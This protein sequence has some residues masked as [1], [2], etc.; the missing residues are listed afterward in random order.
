MMQQR[1][2]RNGMHVAF[3][4]ACEIEPIFSGGT[5][6]EISLFFA[7]FSFGRYGVTKDEMRVFEILFSWCEY[8]IWATNH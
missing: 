5:K 1:R 7:K 8:S 4:R 6:Q 3:K 2:V